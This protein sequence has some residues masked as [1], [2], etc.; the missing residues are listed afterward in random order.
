MGSIVI[1][2]VLGGML[3]ICSWSDIRKKIISFQVLI[4]AVSIILITL[5]I[6]N[7]LWVWERII[8]IGIGGIL[9]VLSKIT[10]GQ[11]GLGDGLLFC[12]T[13]LAIG[14]WN[15]LL[16]LSYSLCLA[17]IYSSVIWI[18]KWTNKYKT[19]PFVPF[20]LLGYIGV[21]LSC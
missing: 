14:G 3:I 17:F 19:I 12:V 16:L 7:N 6:Q 4:I 21:L 9:L 15:N 13:G 10:R 5:L 18:R 20:V 1:K 8:G 2:L 11:I